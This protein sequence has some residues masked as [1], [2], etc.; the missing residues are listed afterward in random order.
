M[1]LNAISF[2]EP[3]LWLVSPFVFL[4]MSIA[5]MPVV[6]SHFWHKYYKLISIGLGLFVMGYYAIVLENT[7]LPIESLAEYASFISLLT[8]LY[9]ASG[10]IYIFADVESKPF[11]NIIFLFIAAVL[12]NSI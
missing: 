6:F 12:T 5:V 4:L 10:G 9:V 7:V 3:P 11:T 2:Q 8:V 1:F